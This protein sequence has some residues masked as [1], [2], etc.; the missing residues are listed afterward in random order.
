MRKE[1]HSHH[2]RVCAIR[3]VA[4]DHL[5]PFFSDFNE[6]LLHLR[7]KTDRKHTVTKP[8]LSWFFF[9]FFIGHVNAQV[10]KGLPYNKTDLSPFV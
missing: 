3:E 10:S 8:K 1:R 5:L 6:V 4:A 7:G 9:F 2:I